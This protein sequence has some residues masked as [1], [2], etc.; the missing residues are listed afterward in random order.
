[1][2]VTFRGAQEGSS[3]SEIVNWLE[4]EKHNREEGKRYDYDCYVIG[5]VSDGGL[6]KVFQPF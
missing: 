4:T 5:K 2:E 6:G 3:R 1:M